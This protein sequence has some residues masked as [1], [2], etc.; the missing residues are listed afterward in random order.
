MRYFS[1]RSLASLSFIGYFVSL[2]LIQAALC[3]LHQPLKCTIH[4]HPLSQPLSLPAH[5]AVIQASH[6]SANLPLPHSAMPVHHF[7]H[8]RPP[9]SPRRPLPHQF[10]R[11]DSQL[12]THLSQHVVR[13]H[14]LNNLHRRLLSGASLP[15]CFPFELSDKFLST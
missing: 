11:L 15:N 3:L 1:R 2:S 9:V 13:T 14:G 4:C 8:Q 12:P 6:A 5:R 10:C 7:H